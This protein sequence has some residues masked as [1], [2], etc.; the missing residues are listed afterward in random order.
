MN[1]K[2]SIHF[3]PKLFQDPLS[4][5]EVMSVEKSVG[6]QKRRYIEGI[7][8]GLKEDAHRERVSKR[9]IDKFMQLA[10]SGDVLLYPDI[11]GIKQSEDIG[12]L[13]QADTMNNGDW[14]TSYRLY[15]EYDDPGQMKLEKINNLWRQC[16]GFPPY[17]KPLRKGFSIEGVIPEGGTLVDEKGLGILDNIE[18]DGVILCPRPAYHD[19]VANAVYKALEI[20]PPWTE[21]KTQEKINGRLNEVM[22]NKDLKNKYWSK[23]FDIQA[24]LQET[25]EDIMADGQTMKSERLNIVFDEYKAAMVGL[26]MKSQGIFLKDDLNQEVAQAVKVAKNKEQICKALAVNLDALQKIILKGELNNVK[27]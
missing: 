2:I 18:L 1:K 26:L 3:Q 21:K 16:M 8:S 22:V 11:H 17:K 25:V 9:C 13:E 14:W 23:K 15:D 7:S 5:R 24:A 27:K 6:G 10:N 19:S 12:I 20:M 4:K